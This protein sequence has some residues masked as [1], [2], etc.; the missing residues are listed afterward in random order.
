[1]GTYAGDYDGTIRNNFIY[2]DVAAFDCGICLEQA[3]GARVLSNTV[4]V[5][6]NAGGNAI[7]YRFPNSLVTIDNTIATTIQLRDNGRATLGSVQLVPPVSQFVAPATGDLHLTA[8]ALGA[9]DR[10]TAI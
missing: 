6:G 10:G 8:G 9:I 2:A 3:M 1:M 4:V 7:E 5:T